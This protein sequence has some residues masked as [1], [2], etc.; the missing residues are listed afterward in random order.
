[1]A[2]AQNLGMEVTAEGV[3]TQV[4]ADTLQGLNCTSAQGFLF[5]RPVPAAEAEQIIVHG[6]APQRPLP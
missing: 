3:E 4:Q 5:S 1:V 6:I 2:L